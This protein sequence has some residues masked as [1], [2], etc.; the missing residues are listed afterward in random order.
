MNH[1]TKLLFETVAFLISLSPLF[2]NMKYITTGLHTLLKIKYGFNHTFN[3]ICVILFYFKF[4]L[5][6]C[7]YCYRTNTNDRSKISL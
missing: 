3:L 2:T 1:L 6:T 4:K 7:E 5:C